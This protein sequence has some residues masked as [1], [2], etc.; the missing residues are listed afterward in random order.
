MAG[1]MSFTATQDYYSI[2]DIATKIIPCLAFLTIDPIKE[3]RVNAFIAIK[4]FLKRL[5]KVSEGG[6][7]VET[8]AGPSTE[9][10][11]ADTMLSWAYNSFAKTLYKT[12][13]PVSGAPNNATPSPPQTNTS[14]KIVAQLP[15][16]STPKQLKQETTAQLQNKDG[17][18]EDFGDFESESSTK[19]VNNTKKVITPIVQ[20]TQGWDED[21]GDDEVW[22]STDGVP[23]QEQTSK[24]VEDWNEEN[25]SFQSKP[26]KESKLGQKKEKEVSIKENRTKSSKAE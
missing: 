1:L 13:T 17:W 12:T 16:V 11:K 26:T 24:N 7:P 3:V 8:Q 2:E 25:W 20:P 5:E 15:P 4:T 19:I 22:E 9:Q 10:Q 6:S 21:F 18:D 23:K 14:Q